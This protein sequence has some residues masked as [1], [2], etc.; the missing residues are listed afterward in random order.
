MLAHAFLQD[1]PEILE[2]L[3][4][5]SH[6]AVGRKWTEHEFPRTVV[7]SFLPVSALPAGLPLSNNMASFS[8][9]PSEGYLGTE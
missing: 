5:L 1:N 7:V 2:D 6:K 3:A 9:D 4:A 8:I